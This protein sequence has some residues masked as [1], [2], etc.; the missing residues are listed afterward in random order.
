MWLRVR[1]RIALIGKRFYLHF[2]DGETLR[3]GVAK[4]HA[5]G[6]PVLGLGPGSLTFS[7]R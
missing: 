2:T 5:V 3:L 7:S 1:P 6:H 4:K